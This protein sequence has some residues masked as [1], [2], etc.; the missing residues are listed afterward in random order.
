MLRRVVPR[1]LLSLTA[2]G[3]GMPGCL[4]WSKLESGACGDGFLGREEACDDGNRI[5]GDGCSDSCKIEPAICGDGRKDPGEDCDDANLS[6]NDACVKDCRAATCG[7]GLLWELEEACDDGNLTAGDGCSPTC[8]VETAPTGP[9]CGDGTLDSDEACDDG[10]ASNADSCLNGCSFATCGDG[11][12][13]QGVE[14]CDYSDPEADPRCTHGCML[15][16]NTPDAYFR[17]GNAHCYTVHDT[18][19]SEAQARSVCQGEGGDL[20][21]VTSEAEGND[22]AAKLGLAG[23][24]WLGLLT[25]N[26]GN[27]WVSGE[28][29]KYTSFAAG[30]PS[31]PTLRCVSFDA[32]PPSDTWSSQG[33]TAK[34]AFVC[35]RVPA[36]GFPEDHHAYRLHTATLDADHARERCVADGGHLATLETDAERVFVGKNVGL[37]TWVDASDSASEGRFV[38]PS[39]EVVDVT[40]FAAGQ[41]DDTNGTQNCLLQNVGDKF[42]DAPCN[43]PHAFVCEFE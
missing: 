6:N 25:S 35:E 8:Q 17:A 41:P 9:R 1:I 28:N 22:V 31:D 5:S 32:A 14:E 37:A 23:P 11:Y 29:T 12:V 43:E 38:W 4:D 16:A 20:W 15:C 40:A 3:A 24:Y 10:N 7:D 36:F 34:L 18:A 19:T 26:T 13:R 33:C 42:A 2:L 21:T 39:G 27:N 30:E